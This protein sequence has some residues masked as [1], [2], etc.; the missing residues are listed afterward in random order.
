M[1]G[2]ITIMATVTS[3]G[4]WNSVVSTCSNVVH[5]ASEN[6]KN[7]RD[8]LKNLIAGGDVLTTMTPFIPPAAT[9]FYKEMRVV[10]T[11]GKQ[12]TGAFQIVP[13]VQNAVTWI[14]N[15]YDTGNVNINSVASV[16][17]HVI[18]AHAFVQEVAELGSTLLSFAIPGML[19]WRTVVAVSRIV[20]SIFFILMGDPTKGGAS[21][22]FGWYVAR[23]A[24]VFISAIQVAV[25]FEVMSVSLPI[26]AFLAALIQFA[27]KCL[28]RQPNLMK[29]VS[30]KVEGISDQVARLERRLERRQDVPVSVF[31]PNGELEVEV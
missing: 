26:I 8:V 11:A 4:P 25:Y 12:L 15:C 29:E 1:R 24:I 28:D 13:N 10:L 19:E 6:T 5:N 14:F 7:I 27:P 9:L 3:A 31:L 16:M 2:I 17:H 21:L 23:C 18:E 22:S 20:Q 30:Q